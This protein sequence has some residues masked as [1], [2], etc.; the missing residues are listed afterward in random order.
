MGGFFLIIFGTCMASLNLGKIRFIEFER[1]ENH[2]LI[3]SGLKKI[4]TNGE[5]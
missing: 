3:K 4:R 1:I 5:I 2:I